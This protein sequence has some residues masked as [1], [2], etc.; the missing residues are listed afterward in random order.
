MTALF[1]LRNR[2]WLEKAL[3]VRNHPPGPGPSHTLGM[4]AF[5]FRPQSPLAGE[6]PHCAEPPARPRSLAYA[7]DDGVLF[8]V[9]NRPW[10][11][12]ALIVRNHPPGPGPSHTL[13][14]TA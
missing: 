5:V 8:F 3:I 10:L 2:P 6:G 14:M 9:R 13:G 1:F 4:T 12:K 7:R 11:E